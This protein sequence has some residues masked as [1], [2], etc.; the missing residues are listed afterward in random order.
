MST[1]RA[2]LEVL[3][4]LA[5]Q[6]REVGVLQGSV[7]GVAFVLAPADPVPVMTDGDGDEKERIDMTDLRPKALREREQSKR[8]Y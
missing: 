1:L 8:G 3:I 6:L 2:N 5:P 4:E 7:D